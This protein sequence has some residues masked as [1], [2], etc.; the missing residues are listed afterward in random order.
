MSSKWVWMGL[1][2][3]GWLCS[4]CAPKTLTL[5]TLNDFHGALYESP[6]RKAGQV[7][8]GLPWLAAVLQDWRAE[9]PP[10]LLL[11][12]GDIFQG[13]W[14]V[15][16]SQ[17]MAAVDAYNLLGVDAAAVGNHEF[18]YGGLEEGHV[19]RG[20]L[21]RA[22]AMAQ[23]R[24]LSANI[25]E[26]GTGLP[27]A[28][29]G[30][31]AT[32]ILKKGRIRIGVIGLSTTDTPATTLKKNV[33]DLDFLDVVPVVRD[34]AAVLR[35]QGVDLVAVV[36]HLS[37][38]CPNGT[39]PT[40]VC[41]PD[42]EVGRLLTEL[43]EGTIDLLVT[44]HS[45][46]RMAFRFGQTLVMQSGSK[47]RWLGRADLTVA[48][49]G[50]DW[51]ASKVWEPVYLSHAPSAPGCGGGEFDRR[52][53]SVAG[54]SVAPNEEALALIDR[55]E[56]KT[57][58][59]CSPAGCTTTTLRR[60]RHGP[61]V[62]G[63]VVADAMR[64]AFPEA[65]LAITNAGG[66]RDDL[67]SGPLTREH[68]QAVMPFD[69]RI[70]LVEISG[71]KL[72]QLFQIGTS[73]GHGPIQISGAQLTLS[74]APP[75]A[76]DV[77]GD[78]LQEAWEFNRFCS[79]TVGGEAVDPD[80]TY[81]LA[82]TDFLIGGGDHLGPAFATAKH[83]KDGPLLRDHLVSWFVQHEPCVAPPA[84]SLNRLRTATCA[85]VSKDSP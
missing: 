20:A 8:G 45:H 50:I 74:E 68:I 46:K 84:D 1:T 83:M 10:L 71:K 53:Q 18:D 79:A 60:D 85:P 25:V 29:P 3:V 72:N 38:A 67:P 63:S 31:A 58:S 51:S 73:G 6:T 76:T 49:N 75:I 37:G 35:K 16:A 82:T 66:L 47:G 65:D 21:E 77:N 39:R 59:L 23:W 34:Q 78:G 22:G 33:V 70:V 55:W 13:S 81:T 7:S 11:D 36:G 12:G 27:W 14:P 32:A 42:G 61:S 57:G 19:L 5:A 30:F 2:A 15:N 44:G 9:D 28:P 24:W 56:I 52:V 54:V 43:P 17:G 69:N 80:R 4:A 48:E 62:L 26:K 40:D 64:S 41:S